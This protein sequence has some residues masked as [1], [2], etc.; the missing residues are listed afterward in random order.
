MLSISTLS[1]MK[2]MRILLLI[3]SAC[4]LFAQQPIPYNRGTTAEPT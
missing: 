1:K 2:I 4:G 3:L